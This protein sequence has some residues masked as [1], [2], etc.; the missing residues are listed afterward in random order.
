MTAVVMTAR[1]SAFTVRPARSVNPM[2]QPLEGSELICPPPGFL[3][4]SA[5]D[6][7]ET[8]VP[9]V[10]LGGPLG[11]QSLALPS[12]HTNVPATWAV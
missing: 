9:E 1:W 7:T 12:H 11:F 10:Y 6:Y 3:H 4:L 8:L 5:P 2:A